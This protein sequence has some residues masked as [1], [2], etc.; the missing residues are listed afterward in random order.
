MI[1]NRKNTF[2]IDALKRQLDTLPQLACQYLHE[3]K[4]LLSKEI[5]DITFKTAEKRKP[6]K[7]VYWIDVRV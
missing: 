3:E 1:S 4:I 5:A 6:E 2:L 7:D